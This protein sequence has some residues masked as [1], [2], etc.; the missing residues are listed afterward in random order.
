MQLRPK[1]EAPSGTDPSSGFEGSDSCFC[2]LSRGGKREKKEDN[3]L[4]V[5]KERDDRRESRFKELINAGFWK[6]H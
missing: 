4:F 5:Q 2:Y 1:S 6:F 3:R